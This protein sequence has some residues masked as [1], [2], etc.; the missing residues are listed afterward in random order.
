[1]APGSRQGLPPPPSPRRCPRQG[2]G[3]GTFTQCR[4]NRPAQ[5][6]GLLPPRPSNFH[7]PTLIPTPRHRSTFPLIHL[8]S[9]T[10][11]G[12]IT[13]LTC[14]YICSIIRSQVWTRPLPSTTLRRNPTTQGSPP[15]PPEDSTPQPIPTA[16]TRGPRLKRKSPRP[17]TEDR[18][19]LIP[20]CPL[21]PS[22][23]LRRWKTPWTVPEKSP[24]G[25]TR[26]TERNGAAR[27][28]GP[29]GSPS[30]S[31][32]KLGCR[33]LPAPGHR[34]PT[35]YLVLLRGEL[36]LDSPLPAPAS[37]GQRSQPCIGAYDG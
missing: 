6:S 30:A 26:P 15:D 24:H 12:G 23:T 27:S 28:R 7:P 3:D 20:T 4:S 31:P 37:G 36:T 1:M 34:R 5:Q 33:R 13:F 17:P 25:A 22:L 11:G 18:H 21:P 32:N 8:I 29:L 35:G 19:L 2:V 16:L 10:Y 14:K 9:L